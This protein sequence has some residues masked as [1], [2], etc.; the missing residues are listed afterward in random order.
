MTAHTRF[1]HLNPLV[2]ELSPLGY[3][4][5]LSAPPAPSGPAGTTSSHNDIYARFILPEGDDD[6][7]LIVYWPRTIG[8]VNAP[9]RVTLIVRD[10]INHPDGYVN[11]RTGQHV[12]RMDRHV[13]TVYGV[14]V[15]TE[16]YHDPADLHA[17]ATQ[18][19]H[20]LENTDA[21]RIQ[22]ALIAAAH[23]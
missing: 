8:D 16:L 2:T 6:V 12:D 13:G 18:A 7:A 10:P 11:A 3:H 23:Q 17:L 21:L 1:Q 15:W 9:G 5:A 20:L 4:L 14:P 22:A 19:R